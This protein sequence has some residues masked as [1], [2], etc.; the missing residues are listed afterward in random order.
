MKNYM[1]LRALR[2]ILKIGRSGLHTQAHPIFHL[3]PLP[4]IFYPYA[5]KEKIV[6]EKTHNMRIQILSDLHLEMN[7]PYSVAIG[8]NVDVLVLAGDIHCGIRAIDLINE[9][10][11][12]FPNLNILYVLG[13]HE[14]YG[15]D[16]NNIRAYWKNIN[17]P[18]VHILDNSTVTIKDVTFI[19]ST[20][21]SDLPDRRIIFK[22]S[23]YS[24]IFTRDAAGIYR[25]ISPDYIS[26]EYRKN[27]GFLTEE[28]HR[29]GKKVVITHHLPSFSL[30][31]SE[32]AHL[33]M[34]NF[35][36]ASNLD[37]LLNL[38]GISAWICG[39]THSSINKIVGKTR[40][41]SNPK[42]YYYN[43]KN[44]NKNFEDKFIIEI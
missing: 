22:I 24:K 30:I 12:H 8:D 9:L 14:F 25:N 18:N 26:Q 16:I 44:E 43:G 23:D 33:K 41:I 28:V 39:H 40:V 37:H 5:F 35:A 1:T 21:W 13:N 15:E 6:H 7:Y 17:I 31:S 42:G 19:G 38:E 3:P 2:N 27:V 34:I 11:F 20:L 29:Y 36:F 32:Y 10:H 4:P